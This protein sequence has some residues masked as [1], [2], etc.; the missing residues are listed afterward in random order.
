[1]PAALRRSGHRVTRP[2]IALIGDG[3]ENPLNAATLLAAAGMFGSPCR[4]RDRAGLAAAWGGA[5]PAA[6]AEAHPAAAAAEAHP[7]AG[8][9]TAGEAR[10]CP[11][12]PTIGLEEL[13]QGYAPLLALDTLPGAADLYGYRLPAGLHPALVVGNERRGI[14]A[15]VRALASGAVQIPMPS[16]QLNC[17]NVAVAAAVALYALSRGG[18][19]GLQASGHPEQ[20]RPELLLLAPGDHVEL[21]S[22]IRSAGAFGWGRLFVEDRRR[23]WFGV[24]RARVAEGRAAARRARNPIHVVPA[25]AGCSFAFD[26]VCVVTTRPL[27]LPLHRAKLAGGPRQVIAIPDEREAPAGEEDWQRLGRVVRY[28]HLELP[29]PAFDYRYRLPA[30]IAL[31][32]VARQVGRRAFAPPRPQRPGL[33][34]DRALALLMEAQG[35]VLDLEDLAAY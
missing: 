31:A 14:A 3:I 23:V 12:L 4:F 11:D 19:A 8:L 20:R 9:P 15:D 13:R 10:P 6:A 5:R 34:Y 7:A 29:S 18:G 2:P 30:S 27:G 33:A 21:G 16:R 26:E 35:E 17:L 24:E 28:V 32:E 22:T 25:P 1:M